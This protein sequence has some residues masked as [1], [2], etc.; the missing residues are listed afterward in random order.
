M[1]IAR[2]KKGNACVWGGI[3]MGGGAC[4]FGWV[5][6]LVL[7]FLFSL[8]FLCFFSFLFSGMKHSSGNVFCS[9]RSPLPTLGPGAPR[10][11]NQSVFVCACVCGFVCGFQGMGGR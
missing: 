1:D 9:Q 6:T 4:M 2:E 10:P 7:V 8:K 11:Y 3:E 5:C